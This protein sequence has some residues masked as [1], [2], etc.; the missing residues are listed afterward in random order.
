M[1]GVYDAQAASAPGVRRDRVRDV[2][3]RM[4][5]HFMDK[6]VKTIVTREEVIVIL[7]E[8]RPMFG[9]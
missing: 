5:E 7:E 8:I 3:K 9:R 6:E 2:V 1:P 4:E